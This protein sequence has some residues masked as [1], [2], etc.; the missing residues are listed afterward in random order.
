[1]KDAKLDKAKKLNQKNQ[2]VRFAGHISS[3]RKY[4]RPH[5]RHSSVRYS[6]RSW[7]CLVLNF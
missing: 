7:R 2:V 3:Y 4:S 5:R 1:M 6:D